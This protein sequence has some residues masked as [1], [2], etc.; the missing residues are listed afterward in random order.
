MS[1]EECEKSNEGQ[2]GIAYYRFGTANIGM[3]GCSKHLREIFDILS[4]E[5][6]RRREA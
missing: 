2:N 3:M 6:K 4:E 1:C 5:Q